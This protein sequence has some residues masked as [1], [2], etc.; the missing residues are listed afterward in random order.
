MTERY[1]HERQYRDGRP[2]GERDDYPKGPHG[3]AEFLRDWDKVWR[4]TMGLVDRTGIV[5]MLSN[6]ELFIDK[7][8]ET[9]A[10]IRKEDVDA[11]RRTTPRD[12]NSKI[13]TLKISF[14]GGRFRHD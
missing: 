5:T 2:K 6:D 8:R 9:E 1:I 12:L 4:D 11:A 10:L 7:T 13:S 14:Y 3:M